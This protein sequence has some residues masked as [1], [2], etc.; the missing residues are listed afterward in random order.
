MRRMILL[1]ALAL[2]STAAFAQTKID[3]SA[4]KVTVFMNGAQVE[5]NTEFDLPAG[6]STLVF[7]GLSPYLDTQSVQV[8]AKGAFTV[9]SVK[10][11]FNYLDNPVL[12][13]HQQKL[14]DELKSLEKQLKEKDAA[15]AVIA[16]QS[17]ILK[18]NC[19]AKDADLAKIKELNKYYA[20]QIKSLKAGELELL[21]ARETL[22]KQIEKL[23]AGIAQ[24]N[25]VQLDRMSE[26]VVTVN[27]PAACKS[28]FNLNYYVRNAGWYPS[29]D[30][31][32]TN[33]TE[34][35][36]V[37]Y[38]ANVYQNTKED[39]KNVRLSLSSSNPVLGNTAPELSTYWLDYPAKYR[40]AGNVMAKSMMFMDAAA[41][42]MEE[43]ASM[44]VD[45]N[46][47]YT[48]FEFEI[49]DCY[50]V[51]SNNNAVVAEVGHYQIPATFGYQSAP[52]LDKDAFL[53][54]KFTDW[55]KLHLLEG[56]ASVYFENRFVGKSMMNTE[57]SD[58]LT[59]SL[60]RDRQI[61][62][63]R[64]KE[65]DKTSKKLVG[66]SQTQTIGWKISVRNTRSEAVELTLFDQIPVSRNSDIVVTADALSGGELDAATGIVTWTLKLK[67]GEQRDL[68]LRYKVKS[69]KG[70]DLRVE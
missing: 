60:G 22:Q 20:A 3:T 59:F 42:A 70:S 44:E 4:E 40:A 29:Y 13:E 56:E 35:I 32:A 24:Q 45:Y 7:T 10:H 26:V 14:Q 6:Q 52:K 15:L 30:V 23:Q 50:S 31:R 38:K 64:K 68:A 28:A 34:P 51:P 12:G 54:A 47:G 16:A 19:S 39:W 9:L 53:V 55:E 17:E 61:L 63:D 48:G 41:P 11:Q 57:V 65:S 62:I 18:E 36:T 25:G 58:T 5:R 21:E 69:P 33:L 66:N 37:V 67:P 43:A 2:C 1:A 46:Q 8:N 49:K 27:A